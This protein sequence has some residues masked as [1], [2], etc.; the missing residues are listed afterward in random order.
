MRWYVK[1]GQGQG[2]AHANENAARGMYES[3]LAQAKHGETVSMH[4]CPHHVDAPEP[5]AEWYDCRKD[6]RAQYEETVK[7]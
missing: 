4:H 2:S 7:D 5:H 6:P 1:D 3:A